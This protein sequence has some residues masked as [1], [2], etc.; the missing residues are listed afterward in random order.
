MAIDEL[1]QLY[2]QIASL[3]E[4]ADVELRVSARDGERPDP[5]RA[6]AAGHIDL[7]TTDV[8]IPG[9]SGPQVAANLTRLRPG[10]DVLYVSGDR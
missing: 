6:S 9:M 7:L 4:Q 10:L 8:V 2:R 3:M 1:A 5:P